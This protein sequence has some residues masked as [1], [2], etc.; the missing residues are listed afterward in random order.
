MVHCAVQAFRKVRL[1]DGNLRRI[2]LPVTGMSCAACGRRVEGALSGTDGVSS[3]NV[4]LATEK[5][6]VEYDPARAGAGALLRAV[7]DAGYGVERR[8]SSFGVTG[9]SCASCVASVEKALRS[10][11][12]VVG[13]SVNLAAERATVEY[14]AGTV[15][16]GDL[17]RSIEGAGYGV[18]GEEEGPAE[19]V[20]A[21]EYGRLRRRFFVAAALTVLVVA[22]GLPL[23][24]GV[25][26]AGRWVPFVLLALGTP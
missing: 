12:G 14:L 23:M 26:G 4:N 11:P 18:V 13:A 3:A 17:Q 6:S 5:A 7:E 22:G 8:E 25:G 1:L 15:R 9:M 24:L 16:T 2:S 10:V 21:L 19:D 20:R